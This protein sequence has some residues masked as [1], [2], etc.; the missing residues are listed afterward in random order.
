MSNTIYRTNDL[1]D[2]GGTGKVQNP[3]GYFLSS[4]DGVFNYQ[5]STTPG[6]PEAFPLYKEQPE[7][8]HVIPPSVRSVM[9]QALEVL[10]EITVNAGGYDFGPA[11]EG[12]K[13]RHKKAITALRKA[14]DTSHSAVHLSHCNMGEYVGSC[15]YG[16]SD[17]PA[18]PLA[19]APLGMEDQPA[20]QGW[21]LGCNPDNCSGC[22]GVPEAVDGFSNHTQQNQVNYLTCDIDQV[23]YMDIYSRPGTK[24]VFHGR[25]GYD[26]EKV[27]A[28][29][30]LVL[31]N[32]Y[33]VKYTDVGSCSSSVWFYEAE[34]V[35]NTVMFGPAV[36]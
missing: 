24:V 7:Q 35:F 27:R 1:A 31:G 32:T 13:K 30:S 6:Y 21:C 19:T 26:G 18:L 22:G 23:C 5:V 11:Y 8:E 12:A 20:Q 15:K 2:C 14:L 34:G 9:Q 29:K 25:G 10:E 16:E 4:P 33:T 17:C 28:E 36:Q 3:V